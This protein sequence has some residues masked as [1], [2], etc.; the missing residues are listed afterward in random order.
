MPNREQ[1]YMRVR[2]LLDFPLEQRP[3]PHS[4]F[5]ELIR[6]EQFQMNKLGNTGQAWTE[7]SL[8]FT[9]V[10]GQADY[11]ISAS[12]F[13]RALT[14][15]RLLNN[16]IVPVTFTNFPHEIY[17]QSYD[18]WNVP[19]DSTQFW[20]QTGEKIAFYRTSAGV[21]K[22][23]LFPIPSEA[24]RVYTVHY[25]AGWQD[26][27]AFELSDVPILLEWSDYRTLKVALFLLPKAEW[28]GLSRSENSDKRRELGLSL[29]TQFAEQKE[30]FESFIRNPQIET[31]SQIGEWY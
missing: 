6:T 1:E 14:V 9:S 12:D 24:G 2:E 27:T 10:L 20:Y 15:Y 13:G 21:K 11:T 31:I 28:E 4:I 26:W 19:Q 29:S 3:G 16:Q 23:R 7:K 22:A 5:S 18:F 8:T 25:A 30:E 17:D